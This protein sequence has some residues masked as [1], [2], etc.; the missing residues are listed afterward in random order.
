MKDQN[1]GLDL[2]FD[3]GA[4]LSAARA[5]DKTPY[6]VVPEGFAVENLSRMM[7]VP[8]RLLGH[9]TLRDE[10]SFIAFV[11]LHRTE[12]TDLYYS[13]DRPGFMAVF[14]APRVGEPAWGDH[15]ASYQCPLSPQWQQWKD[16]DGKRMNQEEFALF[17]ERNLPD[18]VTPVAADL[19]EVV[20]TLQAKKKVNFVSGLRLSN[21][22]NEF[23]Y[24]EQIDGSAAKGKLQ[25]PE[26]IT[27][28]IPVFHNGQGYA[29]QAKFRYRIQDSRLSMWY[30]L[31]RPHVIVE[32]ATKELR[33]RIEAATELAALNG[34]PG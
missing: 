28:G 7:D 5:I 18:I 3:A 11:K 33:Q 14:N 10:E 23:T 25:I 13:V 27:L 2:M 12:N 4:A 21:G 16:N 30:E 15:K 9:T 1:N 32:D 31:V 34:M 26:E 8:P 6:V 22:A 20:T 24:E 19:L 29:V 17:V